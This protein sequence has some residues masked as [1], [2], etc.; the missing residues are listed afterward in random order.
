MNSCVNTIT[1]GKGL[2]SGRN[3]IK[4]I[5]IEGKSEVNEEELYKNNKLGS[6]G[7]HVFA[8]ATVDIWCKMK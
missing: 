2:G 8:K 3:I 7:E 4:G 1:S 5:N 6:E